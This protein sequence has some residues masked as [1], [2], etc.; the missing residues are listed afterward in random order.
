MHQPHVDD[1]DLIADAVAYVTELR[2]EVEVETGPTKAGAGRAVLEMVLAD[3]ALCAYVRRWARQRQSCESKIGPV[4][5][6]PIDPVYRR[7]R[8]TLIQMGRGDEAK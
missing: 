1:P 7:L 5:H 3:P 6:L 4:L 8:G 2:D